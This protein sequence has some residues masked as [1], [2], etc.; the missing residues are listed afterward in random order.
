MMIRLLLTLVSAALFFLCFPD[1]PLPLLALVCLVPFAVAL[2]DATARTGLLLGAVLGFSF[3]LIA[4]WW[5]ANGFYY[6]VRLSWPAAWFWTA[7]ACLV[8]SLPYAVFGFLCGKFRWMTTGRG[9]LAAAATFAV[10][11]SWYPLAFPG[12]YVHSLYAVPRLIQVVDLGGVP[13]LLFLVN[14]INFLT[15]GAVLDRR[16]QG[17]IPRNVVAAAAVLGLMTAYGTWRLDTL[18]QEMAAADRESRV[19]VAAIQPNLSLRRNG[20]PQVFGGAAKPN[21][22][23]TLLTLSEE[24]LQRF[25]QP[26]VVVWP[27]LPSG[28]SCNSENKIWEAV[29]GLAETSG[30][31]FIVNCY[32]YDPSAGG[33]YNIARLINETGEFG[34]IYRKRILLPFG[35][36]LPGEKRLPWL[37]RLF[38]RVLHYIPGDDRVVLLPVDGHWRVMPTLCYE[39]LFPGLVR[40]FVEHGGNIIVNLVDDVW[41]GQSDASAVHMSLAVFRAAEFRVPLVRVTNSGNGVFVQPTGEIVAGSR[42]PVFQAGITA[43]PLFV[44]VRRSLYAAWGDGFLILLTG[45]CGGLVGLSSL[46]AKRRVM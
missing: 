39:V 35:E 16:E 32:Q 40:E 44:P 20:V 12:N 3:W 31:A 18:H 11:L 36:Y 28:I 14:L 41:F 21:H 9:R 24:A 23:E 42:T 43:F 37:R 46:R 7:A 5:L 6:Y 13:L 4:A 30:T 17:G 1:G 26:Q 22:P 34:P 33:D 10:L 8:S 15:A 38:P 27:E 29:R 2:K 45:L 25:P 19:T